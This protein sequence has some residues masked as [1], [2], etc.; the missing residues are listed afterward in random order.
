[1]RLANKYEIWSEADKLIFE[2]I[3]ALRLFTF[4]NLS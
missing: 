1:M 3:I 2:E 4:W